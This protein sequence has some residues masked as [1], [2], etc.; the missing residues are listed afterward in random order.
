MLLL[1]GL[2]EETASRVNYNHF[3]T[4]L[5]D[6]TAVL[7]EATRGA[8]LSWIR[9]EYDFATPRVITYFVGDAIVDQDFEDLQDPDDGVLRIC[10]DC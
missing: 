2:C 7:V 5:V 6:G 10:G 3:V 9:A 4:P 8:N 1:K